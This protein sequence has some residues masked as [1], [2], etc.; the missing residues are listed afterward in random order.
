MYGFDVVIGLLLTF[1]ICVGMISAAFTALHKKYRLLISSLGVLSI[2]CCIILAHASFISPQSIVVTKKT[3]QYSLP[4]SLSI[5]IVS[6]FHVYPG[7]DAQFIKKAV[8]KINTLE[9][10]VILLVGDFIFTPGVPFNQ[11]Q[12]LE[13]L[14]APMG[15]YAVLGNHDQGAYREAFTRTRYTKKADVDSLI[16]LLQNANITVLRNQSV[17]RMYGLLNVHIAGIDDLWSNSSSLQTAYDQF[18]TG[19]DV[20]ILLAHNPSIVEDPLSYH[21]SLIASGHTHGGQVRLPFIGSVL[22]LPTS[23]DQSID[24]GV[25]IVDENT[26]LALTSGIGESGARTRL[27]VPPEILFVTMK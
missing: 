15:V 9:P 2:L 24:R 16:T 26:Y 21:Y 4:E 5:A 27:L 11:L 13:N 17:T 20:Q 7:K 22:N 12:E 18:D 1:G 23:I 25:Y 14:R 19:A 6:D 3:I 10:D 8:S